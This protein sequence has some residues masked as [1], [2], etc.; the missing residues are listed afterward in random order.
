MAMLAPISS[1]RFA[2]ESRTDA[3]R[4]SSARSYLVIS[5]FSRETR[6]TR[7]SSLG[8]ATA[9]ISSFSSPRSR[10]LFSVF[11]S[12][13]P[14]VSGSPA[15]YP[16]IAVPP[17]ATMTTPDVSMNIS[18]L[19]PPVQGVEQENDDQGEDHGGH[20]PGVLPENGPHE[21]RL[22]EY[23]D[24]EV[25]RTH[26]GGH[27]AVAHRPLDIDIHI[28]KVVLGDGVRNRDRKQQDRYRGKIRQDLSPARRD[29]QYHKQRSQRRA[30]QTEGGTHQNHFRP[31]AGKSGSVSDKS[32]G[33]GKYKRQDADHDKEE[34]HLIDR[35]ER[36]SGIYPFQQHEQDSRQ[37]IG[38][39]FQVFTA[40]KYL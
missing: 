9:R 12:L 23:L 11:S 20:L 7:G 18:L 1:N 25:G 14:P 19:H 2:Q 27:D 34:N 32:I 13:P 6:A 5:F 31:L 24:S 30:G 21:C 38:N 16:W 28:E 17:D 37:N 8:K 39:E 22:D 4:G 33:N 35:S 10:R 36:R 29:P 26:D 15:K 3:Y 40:T